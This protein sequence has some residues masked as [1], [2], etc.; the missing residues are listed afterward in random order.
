MK[1]FPVISPKTESWFFHKSPQKFIAPSSIKETCKL[2]PY[3]SVHDPIFDFDIVIGA[4]FI[5]TKYPH[6]EI[7]N[8][9]NTLPELSNE[10]H[11]SSFFEQKSSAYEFIF[12]PHTHTRLHIK[13]LNQTQHHESSDTLAKLSF[14]LQDHAHFRHYCNRG[15]F[16]TR[17]I[18]F[19][20][21]ANNIT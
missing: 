21:I 3:K 5:Q 6:K 1:N 7:K 20:F 14:V 10:D 2:L 17:S 16:I 13:L 15:W 18:S 11:V 4:D 12:Y 9:D 19:Y 8:H